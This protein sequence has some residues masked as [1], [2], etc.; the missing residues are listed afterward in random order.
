MRTDRAASYPMRPDRRQLRQEM[1]SILYVD[2]GR[3]SLRTAGED[4]HDPD[5]CEEIPI[6][7][8]RCILSFLH[9]FKVSEFPCICVHEFV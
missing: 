8:L 4:L 2:I 3:I 9:S 7:Q 5:K 6:L 1:L